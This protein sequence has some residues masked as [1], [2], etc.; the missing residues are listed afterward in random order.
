[1]RLLAVVL[2]LAAA[3]AEVPEV[4]ADA[5]ATELATAK[6]CSEQCPTNEQCLSRGGCDEARPLR[7][8]PD[9]GPV[10]AVAGPPAARE[11]L[12][13]RAT[14]DG[15]VPP[16]PGVPCGGDH[17]DVGFGPGSSDVAPCAHVVRAMAETLL[18]RADRAAVFEVV[19]GWDV[20][21]TAELGRERA[22]AVRAALLEAGVPAARL[23]SAE[24]MRGPPRVRL[25]LAPA[26][27]VE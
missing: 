26:A 5:C 13:E 18:D 10:E 27:R 21:E 20:T 1:M 17:G 23:V 16:L 15:A 4:R 8:A 9:A 3:C 24:A 22:R 12:R 6:Y 25:V 11:E 2:I 19:G 7:D 14:R